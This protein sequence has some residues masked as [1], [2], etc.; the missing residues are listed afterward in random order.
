MKLQRAHLVLADISGY[1]QFIRLHRMSLIH[2]EQIIT[3]LLESVIDAAKHPLILNKLEGD[4]ALFYSPI[5]SPE[6]TVESARM[7]LQQVQVF[8]EAFNLR[9]ENL[10]SACSMCACEA[11]GE[12]SN[13]RLKVIIH[14]GTI[15]LKQ[16]RQYEEIAGEDVILVHRLL[17]NSVPEGEYLMLTDSFFS[18][19]EQP[20]SLTTS[21]KM[22]PRDFD[23]PVRIHIHYPSKNR[24]G[25]RKEKGSLRAKFWTFLRI[26]A[27][28]VKRMFFK[29]DRT[30]RNLP[31]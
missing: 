5:A 16:I 18:L 3:D 20:V 30:F 4:A 1:T 28:T 29:S 10:V 24:A 15:L 13:L 26:E 19:L 27:Y 23:E 31:P 7:I 25:D 6:E 21:Q 22:E 12:A 14:T 9:E 2:A 8:F 11:C 17:K